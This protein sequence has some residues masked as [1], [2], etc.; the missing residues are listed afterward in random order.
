MTI[1]CSTFKP[2]PPLDARAPP[3]YSL[4]NS[5]VSLLTV[6]EPERTRFN[7]RSYSQVSLYCLGTR[8]DAIQSEKKS[9]SHLAT[10]T[11]SLKM[12]N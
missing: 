5:Q 11:P 12:E 8:T 6:W 4:S 1:S 10:L 3:V 2:S 7:P 9:K